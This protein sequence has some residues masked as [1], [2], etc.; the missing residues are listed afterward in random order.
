MTSSGWFSCS[1]SSKRGEL[2][3]FTVMMRVGRVRVGVIGLGLVLVIGWRR[4][5]RCGVNAV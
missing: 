1:C 4:T 2:H 5:S 3:S